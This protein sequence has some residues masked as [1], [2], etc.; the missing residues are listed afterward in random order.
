MAKSRTKKA[1]IIPIRTEIAATLLLAMA[2]GGGFAEATRR[3]RRPMRGATQSSPRPIPYKR[4][5]SATAI[6]RI[7]EK[8]VGR[9]LWNI[10]TPLRAE[11]MLVA[12][13]KLFLAGAPDLADKNDPWGAIDGT[14]GGLLWGVC[15]ASGEKIAE[16]KLPAPPVFDGMSSAGGMLFA[17]LKDGRII[18]CRSKKSVTY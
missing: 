16:L 11:A 7:D 5:K 18:C 17:S 2:D 13:D 12:G 3:L 9:S 1:T 15:A 4:V 8:D 14:R 6:E 10:H